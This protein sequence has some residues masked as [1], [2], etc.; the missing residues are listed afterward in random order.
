MNCGV[1]RVKEIY[2]NLTRSADIWKVKTT[3]DPTKIKC[4]DLN[5][6]YNDLANLL[7]VEAVLK[8]HADYRGQQLTFPVQLFSR[9]YMISQILKEYDGSNVKKLATQFGYSEKWIRK[10]IKDHKDHSKS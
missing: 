10:I 1:Y 5:G 3:M 6:A 8:L 2:Y 4:E 7:G 9:E